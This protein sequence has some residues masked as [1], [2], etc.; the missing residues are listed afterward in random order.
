MKYRT[1]NGEPAPRTRVDASSPKITRQ[2]FAP[3]TDVR[4]IIRRYGGVP[5]NQKQPVFTEHDYNTDLATA[6]DN[7]K[8]AHAA[9]E[10][11]PRKYRD[12]FKTADDLWTA[13]KKGVINPPPDT[14][15]P[16]TEE[17]TNA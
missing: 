13:Y 4:T 10:D 15:Q 7:L 14:P 3:Q 11:L 5:P 16:P 2:E 6:L 12:Q 9:F 17:R 1:Q 8:A